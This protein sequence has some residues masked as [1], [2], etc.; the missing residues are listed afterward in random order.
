M[1]L[2]KRKCLILAPHFD[3]EYLMF[4]SFLI[5][6]PGDIDIVFT[7]QGDCISEDAYK[8]E[9]E[10][11]KN[12]TNA[13]CAYREKNKFGKYTIK[14]IPKAGGVNRLGVSEKTH[15]E[16]CETIESLLSNNTWEYYL[17]SCKSI[18]NN[19]RQSNI[20]A[21]SLLRDPYI[22]NIQKVLI[23]TYD[24]ECMFPT[25]DAGK[26]CTQRIINKKEI[27]ALIRIGEH[28]NKKLE[29]FPEKQFRKILRYNGLKVKQPYAQAFSVRHM[30]LSDN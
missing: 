19:H 14:Y 15:W 9:L 28:Y 5:N 3:D 4:G 18:H 7:H 25:E 11:N 29:K 13:L 24:P 16:I 20:I 22:F 21:E 12:F 2:Q 17:Y 23:G 26:F 1:N 8:S 10:E 30:V 27:S 6:Y